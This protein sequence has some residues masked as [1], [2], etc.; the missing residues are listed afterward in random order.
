M[1]K[2]TTAMIIKVTGDCSTDYEVVKVLEVKENC[3]CPREM[4]EFW[5]DQLKGSLKSGELV[6]VETEYK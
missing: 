6:K 2:I 1:L 3:E 5:Q 4:Y